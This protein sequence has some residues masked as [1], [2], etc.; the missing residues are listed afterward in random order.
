M[1]RRAEVTPSEAA[2][3]GP[4]YVIAGLKLAHV[5]HRASGLTDQAAQ[6]RRFARIFAAC[7]LRRAQHLLQ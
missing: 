3:L 4:W 6:E 5:E 2:A 1:N 7:T